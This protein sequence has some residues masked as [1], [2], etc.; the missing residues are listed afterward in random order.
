[1]EGLVLGWK[2]NDKYDP[3]PFAETP[4]TNIKLDDYKDNLI[5]IPSKKMGNH[6][7]LIAQ[8]G[9]GKSFLIGR[10]L[11][12]IVLRT[13]I[14]C[15]IIDP[16]ADYRNFHIVK[17]ITE[18]GNIWEN[19]YLS[20]KDLWQITHEIIPNNNSEGK[21]FSNKWNSKIRQDI[22]IIRGDIN[23]EEGPYEKLKLF[24]P[25]LS[26]T[27]FSSDLKSCRYRFLRL[28]ISF[29][30]RTEPFHVLNLYLPN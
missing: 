24:W 8:S 12:E 10:L 9:S 16:N 2:V 22:K 14:N 6:T 1:M 15:F 25:T 18:K 21:T 17:D 27:L 30:I 4:L 20:K 19:K 13:N 28:L 3:L 11:E 5:K 29:Y 26:E 23:K 7:A